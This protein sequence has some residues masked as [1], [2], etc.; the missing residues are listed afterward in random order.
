[1][2]K[3]IL[4]N[5]FTGEHETWLIKNIGPR[6]FYLHSSIGGEGWIA[7]KSYIK[8]IDSKH[9]TTVWEIHFEDNR[10]ASF[11]ALKFSK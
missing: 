2:T 7:K 10:Y 9:H 5:N 8:N 6:M 3:I 4:D 11:F 1:M